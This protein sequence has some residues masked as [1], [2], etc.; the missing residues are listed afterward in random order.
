MSALVLRSILRVMQSQSKT[1]HSSSC[2]LCLV[3]D[4]LMWYSWL[5]R[6]KYSYYR[7]LSKAMY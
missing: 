6:W 2:A 5:W 7:S 1:Y 4:A 3:A